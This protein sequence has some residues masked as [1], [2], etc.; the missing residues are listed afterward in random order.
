M[1]HLGRRKMEGCRNKVNKIFFITFLS[2]LHPSNCEGFLCV[3]FVWLL[4][5][6]WRCWL[7][8]ICVKNFIRHL[9]GIIFLASSLLPERG[10]ASFSGLKLNPGADMKLNLVLLIDLWEVWG[11]S[12]VGGKISVG[13]IHHYLRPSRFIW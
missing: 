3:F 8:E 1:F 13:F 5:N 7:C 6:F 12:W 10:R 9:P 11:W 2:K 4:M